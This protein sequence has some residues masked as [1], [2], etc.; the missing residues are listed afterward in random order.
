MA[1]INPLRY[2]GYY[3]DQETGLYHLWSRYYD[4]QTGRFINA[5]VLT[6]TGQGMLGY[7]MFAYCLNNPVCRKEVWGATS[8]DCFN[9]EDVDPTDDDKDIAGGKMNNSTTGGN[10]NSSPGGQVS[11]KGYG[12][13]TNSNASSNQT[14][15]P[16][17]T[18]NQQSV[19]DLAK[20]HKNGV[21]KS[22]AKILV[23]YANEYGITNHEPMMHVG[24]SGIWSYTL[25]INIRN[26][27]IPVFM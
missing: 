1:D 16:R 9:P 8:V 23:D 14:K 22:E 19:L 20:E 17:F 3:Y 4:P 13:H 7:N 2:R 24:R 15:S 10:G 27:H 26:I 12:N 25:H 18:P 5:D 11:G 21:T 6:S